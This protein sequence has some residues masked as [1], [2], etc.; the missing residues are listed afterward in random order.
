[1]KVESYAK[2]ESTLLLTTKGEPFDE[3]IVAICSFYG[4]NLDQHNQHTQITILGRL[5]DG[6]N[7]DSIDIPFAINRLRELI[8][9]Q[10]NLFSEIIV[11]VKLILLAPA[12][13]TVSERSC[14]TLRRI[15]T[16][17]RSTMTQSRLNHWLMLNTHKKALGELSL[18]EIA[19]EFCR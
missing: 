12:R 15:R 17:F 3:H 6:L 7:K 18:V 8:Q 11:L 5:V 1:M 13:N 14:S 16:Y 9:P 10:K 4:D 19:N 2:V